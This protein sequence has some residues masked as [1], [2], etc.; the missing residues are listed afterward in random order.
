MGPVKKPV[1]INVDLGENYGNFKCFP[2]EEVNR[3]NV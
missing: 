2:D 3:E 1:K